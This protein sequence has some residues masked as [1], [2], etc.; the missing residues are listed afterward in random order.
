MPRGEITRPTL[1]SARRPTLCA[2]CRFGEVIQ[3]SIYLRCTWQAT[4]PLPEWLL[5]WCS[6]DAA[7]TR[8]DLEWDCLPQRPCGAWQE[9]VD[10][11]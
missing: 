9:R 8:Q 7:R 6:K 1:P 10:A 11:A 3:R 5:L 4:E 2:S